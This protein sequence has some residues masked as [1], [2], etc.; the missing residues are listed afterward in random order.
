MS[1]PHIPNISFT[2][3]HD[4]CTGC[5]VCQDTCPFGAITFRKKSG[6]LVPVVDREQCRNDKGCHLC[7]KICPGTEIELAKMAR[8]LYGNAPTD[9][10]AG[11]YHSVFSGY[12]NDYP[13]RYHA[14]S[15]GLV[16]EFIAFLLE[17]KVIDGAVLTR[18]SEADPLTPV[19]FIARTRE[20]VIQARSSKYCPV[21]MNGIGRLLESQPGKYV[22]VG[23]PCHIQG[24]RKKAAIDKH[25]REKVI[26]YFSIYCSS[27]RTFQAQD[28]LLKRYK[29]KKEE[30]V[31]FAFRDN[32][33]LGDLVIRRTVAAAPGPEERS[34]SV[35]FIRYYGS[36]RS[37]FKPRRC[38]TCIDHYGALAD[39]CFGDLHIKPYSDDKTGI[40]SLIVRN[41]FFGALLLKARA[42][43]RIT[44]DELDV[45]TLNESQKTMLY[46]KERKVRARMNLDRLTGRKTA[47][48][49][50]RWKEKPSLKDYLSVWSAGI[51]R[52]VGARPRLW[53]LIDL[54]N[55]K[56]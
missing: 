3:R 22:I 56:K 26:G 42:M 41:P 33:C 45:H 53:F 11:H 36:L 9:A 20:E 21:S 38:L 51:Q 13:T 40:S 29:V 25:F 54:V 6:I 28:Y 4:L 7:M 15:G 34:I 52:F 50:V 23:L 46:P 43:N 5:G 24:F 35:P 39:L 16:S 30:V 49:D 48:Y 55:R 31:S 1:V 27:N 32:G 14:A 12:S 17:E 47:H 10:R 19:P 8:A 37:F 2:V 18:F 44:L